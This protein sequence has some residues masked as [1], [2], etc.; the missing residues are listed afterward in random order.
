M[1]KQI[2]DDEALARALQ[3]AEKYVPFASMARGTVPAQLLCVCFVSE[4]APAASANQYTPPPKQAYQSS[5]ETLDKY[6]N[7]KSISSDNF[8]GSEARDVD[9]S[10]LQKFQGSQSISSDAFYNNGRARSSSAESTF[11]SPP[12][13]QPWKD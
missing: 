5:A 10:H 11:A 8:F 9:Q 1:A 4:R 7:S 3:E 2:E 13:Y 12:I 6:K